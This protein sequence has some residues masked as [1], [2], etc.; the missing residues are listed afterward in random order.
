MVT[1]KK[2]IFFS[3]YVSHQTLGVY[4]YFSYMD[5]TGLEAIGSPVAESGYHSKFVEGLDLQNDSL[6]T[7]FFVT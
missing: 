5:E 3:D 7:S 1:P 6:E 4:L 2:Y